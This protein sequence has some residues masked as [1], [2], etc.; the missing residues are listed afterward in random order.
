MSER[1]IAQNNNQPLYDD[2]QG[3]QLPPLEFRSPSPEFGD[4]AQGSRIREANRS[5]EKA[6]KKKVIASAVVG[7]ILV[8]GAGIGFGLS[9]NNEKTEPRQE[10]TTSSGAPAEQSTNKTEVLD[11]NLTII[12]A[13]QYTTPED[14]A[15]KYFEI[16][17]VLQ[18]PQVTHA[19]TVSPDRF[20]VTESEYAA[21]LAEPSVE[22]YR[23][24]F[25]SDAFDN[26]DVQGNFDHEAHSFQNH[27][28]ISLKA[29]GKYSQR[30]IVDVVAVIQ[31]TSDT[32]SVRITHHEESNYEEL[33][34]KDQP[35]LSGASTRT[36]K[37]VDGVWK[38]QSILE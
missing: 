12:S 27:A 17:N 1:D 6:R 8:A 23:S 7:S 21:Q 3:N 33:F 36:F 15:T 29:D 38:V 11:P 32:I 37:K 9:R 28:E 16:Y 22:A 30:T 20:K 19:D 34:K 25:T 35:Y 2:G 31:A 18:N 4:D 5:I 14:V 26:P 24:M 10:Q 13:E